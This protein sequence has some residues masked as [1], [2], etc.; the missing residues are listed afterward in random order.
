MER[1]NASS[2]DVARL[3]SDHH[4][5]EAILGAENDNAVPLV[6]PASNQGEN[7]GDHNPQRS[8]SSDANEKL[9]SKRP[10]IQMW[11]PVCLRKVT[12]LAFTLLFTSMFVALLLLYHFSELHHG[13]S[14]QTPRNHYSW[15]YGPTAR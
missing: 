10:T 9:S 2:I 7:P 13:L 5:S 14:T 4:S 3:S 12:L 6:V 15:T 1:H 11:N 8:N